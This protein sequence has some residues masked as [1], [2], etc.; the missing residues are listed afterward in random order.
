MNEERFAYHLRQRLNRGLE[1]ISPSVLRRLEASRHHAL[2]H[3]KHEVRV[4]NLALSGRHGHGFG[5]VWFDDLRLRQ[6]MAILLLLISLFFAVYW[7]GQHYLNDLEDVDSALLADDI[8]P[9]AFL[10]RGF[11]A[12]LD[13]S[14]AE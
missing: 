4:V 6:M 13:D 1:G 7:Q 11:A 2:A 3:Q 10:D 12:W 14:S 9:D 5:G 8:P